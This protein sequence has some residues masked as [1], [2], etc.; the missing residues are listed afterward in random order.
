MSFKT[1]HPSP[2]T[3]LKSITPV[4]M[5]AFLLWQPA[6]ATVSQIQPIDASKISTPFKP[7]LGT[8]VYTIHWGNIKA[9]EATVTIKAEADYYRVTAD[10]KTTK[11]IDRMYKIRYQGEGVISADDFAAV[12]TVLEERTRARKIRTEITYN[13]NG[14]IETVRVRTKRK[15][16]PH[17]RKDKFA[18]DDETLDTFS[19]VFLARSFDWHVGLTEELKVFDGKKN[20]L[21]KL[22]CADTA[23]FR[24]RNRKIDCWVIVPSV[25]DLSKPKKKPK[26][27][28]ATIFISADPSRHI[29]KV[30]TS[31]GTGS[32]KAVLK[33]FNPAK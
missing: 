29:V 15:K 19:A 24:H 1:K 13:E 32:V 8:Y 3:F 22:Q 9:A 20:Y 2:Q 25:V 27:S 5:A 7:P 23:L 16:Q 26:F 10:T 33:Q 6:D 17:V 28:D 4:L 12:K 30:Q 14:E 11:F 18:P 21:V 31:S